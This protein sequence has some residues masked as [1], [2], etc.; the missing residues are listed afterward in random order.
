MLWKKGT[1]GA[2]LT[3]ARPAEVDSG[4]DAVDPAVEATAVIE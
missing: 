1:P 4:A 3:G 2:W